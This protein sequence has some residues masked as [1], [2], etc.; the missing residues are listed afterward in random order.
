MIQMIIRWGFDA[1]RCHFG[2]AI[3]VTWGDIGAHWV[4]C[5]SHFVSFW[6]LSCPKDVTFAHIWRYFRTSLAIMDRFV[7][8]ALAVWY[9]IG[10]MHSFS[11]Y[12]VII[13]LFPFV[14]I[15]CYDMLKKKKKRKKQVPRSKKRIYLEN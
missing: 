2:E 8:H 4:S 14:S 7:C 11:V 3:G 12:Y 1:I 15:F 9:F 5:W 6:Y 10:D 13:V